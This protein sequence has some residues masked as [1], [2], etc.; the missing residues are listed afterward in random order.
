MK[1]FKALVVLASLLVSSQAG[2]MYFDVESG[3]NS[4]GFREYRPPDGRYTQF[5]P[6]GLLGGPNGYLYAEANPLLYTDP[7][8]LMGQGSGVV[9]RPGGQSNRAS[10]TVAGFG[11]MGLMC[12][13]GG[14]QDPGPQFSAELTFG[15]GIEICDPPPPQPEPQTCPRYDKSV[16]VQPPGIPVPEGGASKLTMRGGLFFGPSWKKDGRFCLRLGPH[17]SVPGMPS[18]D[19]GGGPQ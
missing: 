18:V 14:T 5:D 13:S 3:L 11:C 1:Q 2:A 4:N 9:G 12:A 15:G 8:G 6:I 19:L 10:P 16:Q 17:Y 7:L